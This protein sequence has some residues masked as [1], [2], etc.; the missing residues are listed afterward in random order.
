MACVLPKYLAKDMCSLVVH[1]V[2]VVFTSELNITMIFNSQK[3]I[4]QILEIL[5][6]W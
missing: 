2:Q 5:V 6:K 3:A 1:A 4:L